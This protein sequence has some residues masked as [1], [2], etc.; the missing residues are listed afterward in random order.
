[1]AG[2][3]PSPLRHRGV[4]WPEKMAAVARPPL[5]PPP[6]FTP[7]NCAL[8]SLLRRPQIAVP[9]QPCHLLG[10]CLK[11]TPPTASL[12]RRL[13]FQNRL[14]V[15]AVQRQLRRSAMLIAAYSKGSPSPVGAACLLG[16]PDRMPQAEG[17]S[18]LRGLDPFELSC[19][20][21]S[22]PTELPPGKVFASL[23]PN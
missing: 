23:G 15:G 3:G 2:G 16:W 13:Q 17:I 7:T 8:G 11:T 19:Y 10:A 4:S 22:A 9:K 12:R 18:P 21:Y 6:R 5:S 20:Q 14:R 1:M